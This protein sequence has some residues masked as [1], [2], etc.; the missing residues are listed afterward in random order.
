VRRRFG[1][2]CPECERKAAGFLAARDDEGP[3]SSSPAH[4]AAT[5][6]ATDRDDG[7]PAGG[8]AA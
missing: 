4:P 1:E 5:A 2:N 8:L 3:V 6:A 7:P